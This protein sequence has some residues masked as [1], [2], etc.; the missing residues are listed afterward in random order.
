MNNNYS[1]YS[2]EG[3]FNTIEPDK[4]AM[5]LAA[6]AVSFIACA[7]LF[8]TEGNILAAAVVVTAISIL[9]IIFYRVDWG[10]YLFFF[11]ALLFDQ[12]H[13]PGFD[14]ITF[15]ADYFK[16]LKE[17]A[18]IPSF[19]AGVINPVEL[20]LILMLL[21][22]FVAISFRKKS[23]IQHIY[24]W[25]L[26]VIFLISLIASLVHGMK[27]GGEILPALW[28]LRALFYFGFLFFF[29][30]QV[31]QTKRQIEI[32]MWVFIAGVAIKALQ[33]TV[34]FAKLGFSFAGF[35]TITNHEDPVFI[36]ILVIFLISLIILKGNNK[37]RNAL[38]VLLIILVLGFLAGQRRAAYGGLFVSIAAFIILLHGK[39]KAMILKA[40]LP[41]LFI[42]LIY[43]AAF[44]NSDS[45][46]ASPLKLV[47]SGIDPDAEGERYLSNLY[48]E[49]ERYNL[50]HTARTSPVVGIGFGKK[51]INVIP[52]ANIK[53][54]LRDY[55]P[56]NEILWVFVKSGAAG[57]FI[58]WLFFNALIFRSASL[59]TKLR[60]PY[61]KSICILIVIAIVNQMT[62][63][64]YD[65]QLTYYRNMIVL[66]TL[67]GLLPALTNLNKQQADKDKELK[68]GNEYDG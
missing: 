55:I 13:V 51:Y 45:R 47:R 50:A 52:L 3:F 21:A 24:E 53:F 64:Y 66:G 38:L 14:S 30:S 28:E 11:M 4:A 15:K 17:N 6:I 42:I 32:L 60:D 67:C 20:Q 35:E 40:L 59:Y 26:G 34:R 23:K 5:M 49:F 54:P 46:I 62:V 8:E 36:T 61:L 16:N 10:F 2:R 58:F 48:R 41:F 19:S 39:E 63:S 33:G 43:S 12:Y 18:H 29:V 68:E 1:K 25:G 65:L 27:T 37:Q 22:W 44:W 7:V 56:H 57:F 31:I 9:L